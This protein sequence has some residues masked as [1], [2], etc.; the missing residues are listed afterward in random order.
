MKYEYKVVTANTVNAMETAI[1][2]AAADGWEPYL[3]TSWVTSGVTV[4]CV[5]RRFV[6]N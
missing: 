5:L 1:N 2:T 4:G 3:L 6:G